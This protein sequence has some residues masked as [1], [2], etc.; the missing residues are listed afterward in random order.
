[1]TKIKN[2]IQFTVHFYQNVIKIRY[3]SDLEQIQNTNKHKKILV[4]E[5]PYNVI[6]YW[7][8][9]NQKKEN[10]NKNIF[11]YIVAYLYIYAF[12]N[13]YIK[14]SLKENIINSST[15]DHYSKSVKGKEKSKN[16]T[17][18]G[19]RSSFYGTFCFV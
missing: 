17:F 10:L 1:M 13:R 9:I 3:K 14:L 6:Q 12:D 4:K 11:S 18:D 16:S 8:Y 7:K 2:N 15:Y 19:M 5:I